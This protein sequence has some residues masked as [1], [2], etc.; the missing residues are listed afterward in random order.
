MCFRSIIPTL[1]EMFDGPRMSKLR[2]T[3]S[4]E[5]KILLGIVDKW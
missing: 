5:Q 1:W 4:D 3:G 2:E